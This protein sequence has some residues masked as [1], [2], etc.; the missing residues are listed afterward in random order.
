MALTKARKAELLAV[1]RAKHGRKAF[2]ETDFGNEEAICDVIVPGNNLPWAHPNAL[3]DETIRFEFADKVD[4]V[5][6][7]CGF[8]ELTELHFQ[9]GDLVEAA[10]FE[11]WCDAQNN[12]YAGIIATT[13]NASSTSTKREEN[14]LAAAGFKPIFRGMN[15]NTRNHITLWFLSL[16]NSTLASVRVK[17]GPTRATKRPSPA[18]RSRSR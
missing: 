5:N 15:P 18:T 13:A 2:I 11:L 10:A 9:G 4:N 7:C 14:V 16:V 17:K 12:K 1:I 3:D 8:A 6:S